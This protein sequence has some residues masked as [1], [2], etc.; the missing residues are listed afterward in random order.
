[1]RIFDI[2]SWF[3]R[4]VILS[5]AEITRR[6]AKVERLNVVSAWIGWVVTLGYV[7]TILYI[8]FTQT[9]R[10]TFDTVI[11]SIAVA[12]ITW[13]ILYL[14][15]C[16]VSDVFSHFDSTKNL[17][18]IS[19]KCES[20]H[21]V[22]WQS[23]NLTKASIEQDVEYCYLMHMLVEQ[24][25]PIK[26]YAQRV[27]ESERELAVGDYIMCCQWAKDIDKAQD[28]EKNKQAQLERCRD[29]YTALVSDK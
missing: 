12:G 2:G 19:T 16:V 24:Y 23:T 27:I 17:W 3:D 14:F 21:A 26:K 20:Y 18:M 25:P 13:V 1:M 10:V 9:G 7:S 29:L 5:Q 6:A 8:G 15:Y 11:G 4:N 28:D 22:K